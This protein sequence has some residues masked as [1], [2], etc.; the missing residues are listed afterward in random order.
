MVRSKSSSTGS[1]PDTSF[2]V[3]RAFSASRRSRRAA[4]VRVPFGV[5]PQELVLGHS[6]PVGP[7]RQPPARCPVELSPPTGSPSRAA[8]AYCGDAVG[9]AARGRPLRV[10]RQ[11]R[12]H[13]ARRRGLKSRCPGRPDS[14]GGLGIPG[15]PRACPRWGCSCQRPAPGAR[16]GVCSAWPWRLLPFLAVVLRRRPRSRPRWCQSARRGLGRSGLA[17]R[18]PLPAWSTRPRPACS[19][20]AASSRSRP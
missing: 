9:V 18:R 3:A 11:R 12:W 17:H 6:G 8:S 2:S 19:P 14:A 7:S 1:R 10:G 13:R 16:T 4:A 15:P 20:P 5:Q